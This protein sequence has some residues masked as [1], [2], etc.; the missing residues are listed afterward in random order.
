M[1][2]I[3]QYFCKVQGSGSSYIGLAI[4]GYTASSAYRLG[5]EVYHQIVG[6]KFGVI[7][8]YDDQE[9]TVDKNDVSRPTLAEVEQTLQYCHPSFKERI[10]KLLNS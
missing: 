5:D 1:E 6:R 7:L 10:N 9:Y 4:D 8:A 2:K 3:L